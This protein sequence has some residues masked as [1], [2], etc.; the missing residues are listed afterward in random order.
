MGSC[1]KMTP[2]AASRIQSSEAKKGGG[3]VEK[4]SFTSRAQSSGTKN[5]NSKQ[6]SGSNSGSNKKTTG[7]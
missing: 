4:G 7:K 3:K 1:K 2:E 6:S 5:Q